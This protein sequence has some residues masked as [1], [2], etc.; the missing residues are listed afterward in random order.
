M[1]ACPAVSAS[2]TVTVTNTWFRLGLVTPHH[3]MAVSG[4]RRAWQPE[5]MIISDISVFGIIRV[6]FTESRDK[7]PGPPAGL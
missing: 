2:R 3:R 7:L 4:E 6:G 1:P 5:L